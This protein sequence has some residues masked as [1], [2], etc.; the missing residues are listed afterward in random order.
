MGMDPLTIGLI[1]SGI[2]AG[3]DAFGKYKQGK[4]AQNQ[5]GIINSRA[6]G[7]FNQG[8]S[9]YEAMIQQL[10]GSMGGP[11]KLDAN[12]GNIDIQSILSGMNPGNDALNQFL[13]SDPTRQLQAAAGG[14]FDVSEAFKMLQGNDQMQ[15]DRAANDTR[16]GYAGL[17]QRFGGAAQA[18]EGRMRSD[19]AAQVAARN[20]GI[21]QSAF[22]NAA[23][24][25]LAATTSGMGFQFQ[26]A[27]ALSRQGQFGAQLA[28]QLAQANQGNLFR[29][30]QFNLDA[31]SQNWMQKM[32]GIQAG[33]G[34]GQ[35]GFQNNRDLLAIMAGFQPGGGAGWQAAGGGLGDIGQ[36]IAF[37]PM[38]QQL[39]KGRTK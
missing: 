36:L 25:K 33:F 8:S 37:L 3:V 30:N 17:G 9:P 31:L 21:S 5:Q 38:L 29:N 20:A 39:S 12:S 11:M 16:A 14:Q 28:A 24:R 15:I 1:T 26:G 32:Q 18:T 34:M 10:L 23:S 4:A 13:R 2:G 6:E 35:Q 7:M 27:D 22:E 19:F